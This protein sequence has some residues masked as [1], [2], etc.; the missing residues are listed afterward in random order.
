MHAAFD[1]PLAAVNA[2]VAIQSA[3]GDANATGEVVLGVRCGL[4]LGAVER[5]NNDYF[6]GPVNRAVRI[7]SAAYGGQILLSQAVVDCVRARL[8]PPI[9]LRDLGSVRLKDLSVPEDVYQLVHPKL[10]QEFPAL[11]SLE[12]SPNNLSQHSTSFIGRAV[13]LNEVK[14]LLQSTRLLT[15]LGPGGVG[16]TRLSMQV[17]ADIIDEYVDGVW[18]VDLAPVTDPTYVPHTLARVFRVREEP[19]KPLLQTLCAHTK[20]R[21]MLLVLDNCEHLIDACARLVEGLFQEASYLQILTT[22]RE[23]LHIAGEQIF[24]LGVLSL[25]D[26]NADLQG[27]EESEAVRLFVDRARAQVPLFAVTGV[28]V[29]AVTEVCTRLD[30]I[31]LALEL[32]AACISTLPVEVIAERL[33]DRFQ[34]LDRGSRLALPRQKTLRAMLDWSYDLL[35]T[36]EKQLFVQLSVFA[37]GWTLAAAESVA[38]GAGIAAVGIVNL[39]TNLV[40]KSL[41]V[42]EQGGRRYRMLETIQE[43]AHERLRER[44]D[45][46]ATSLRHC[47]YFTA[48]AQTAKPA[49]DNPGRDRSMW[50]ERLDREQDN[51]RAALTWSLAEPKTNEAALQMCGLLE[52]F[53]LRQAQ[54]GEGSKWCEA[55]I[56]HAGGP[57]CTPISAKALLAAGTF[58]Y[59]LGDY[60]AARISLERATA[61]A[62][63]VDDR[64]LQT[65]G[66]IRLGVAAS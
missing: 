26:A 15:L 48:M 41:V 24:S 62:E 12:S 40:E 43:Y 30:G 16:K 27:V 11:R 52:Q 55:A 19:G 60:G 49:L 9:S 32:A 10:R 6:G 59:R 66:L 7:M 13:E 29:R 21:R 31:P 20:S 58:A 17:A 28:N 2:A 65:E 44:A 45:S 25:P 54:S 63:A 22:T 56:A 14:K 42:V 23:P 50:L 38:S 64:M 39:L 47:D 18:F 5:R 34:L 3:V 53:W 57:G 1:D 37:G 35:A 33:S 4:H 61:V 36:E 8:E 51:F 46:A